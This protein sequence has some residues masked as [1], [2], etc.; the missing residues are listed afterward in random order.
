[1]EALYVPNLGNVSRQMST[2]KLWWNIE[3]GSSITDIQSLN[4]PVG[5]ATNSTNNC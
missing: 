3:K 4:K 5:L 2:I 1:M